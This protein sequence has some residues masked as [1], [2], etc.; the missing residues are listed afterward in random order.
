MKES[1]L[2]LII[3][4]I[5]SNAIGGYDYSDLDRLEADCSEFSNY[6]YKFCEDLDARNEEKRCTF[7][8]NKCITTFKRCEDYNNQDICESILPEGFPYVKCVLEGK[9]CVTKDRLCSDFKFGLEANSNCVKLYSGDEKKRCVFINNRCEE[10]FKNCEDYKKN[11]NKEKCESIIPIYLFEEF[12]YKCAF[13]GGKCIKREKHCEDYAYN[14]SIF[15]EDIC[16]DLTP[17][18][19]S[20]RCTFIN[21]KCIEQFKQC[22]DYKGNENK[23]CESIIP[24][25]ADEENDNSYIVEY[26]HKCIFEE[27]K[28]KKIAKTSCSDYIPGKSSDYCVSIELPDSKKTCI[29]TKNKCIET[30]KT[31]EEYE[32][33]NIK[34]D[35]CESIIPTREQSNNIYYRDYTHKCVFENKKCITK[36][37]L[38]SELKNVVENKLEKICEEL[39]VTDTNKICIAFRDKCIESYRECEDYNKNVE[40]EKCEAIIPEEY[41]NIK[42]VY[43]RKNKKC[44][45]EN[46][47]CSSF[48]LENVKNYCELLGYNNNCIYSNGFCLVEKKVSTINGDL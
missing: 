31:C 23:I 39:E 30:Y 25:K 10:Q 42:C 8:N 36:K 7:M 45:S 1:S 14:L 29:F 12:K 43:D 6:K 46:L 24:V 41:S 22:D 27:G 13:E 4:L 3:S 34:Q 48:N 20:K 38:C 40:K 5:I 17:I 21:G 26:K 28:C 15:D 47:S 44:I 18:D 9:N 2:L 35:I 33:K 37:I 32:G 11:V 16:E 19:S